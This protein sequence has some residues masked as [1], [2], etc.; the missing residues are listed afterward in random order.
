MTTKTDSNDD[1][2]DDAASLATEAA[3]VG[4]YLLGRPIDDASVELYV[5]AVSR[6]LA[7]LDP[8]DQRLFGRA[9]RHPWLLG[10]LDGAVSLRQRRGGVRRRLLMMFAILEASPVYCEHFLPQPASRLHVV[11]VAW[12]GTRALIKAAVGLLLAKLLR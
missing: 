5:R 2:V 9:I 10:F 1:D 8:A 3:T 12:A 11:A 6:G 4:R 7:P